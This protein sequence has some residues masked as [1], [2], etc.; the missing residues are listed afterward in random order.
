[1][2]FF[3][4]NIFIIK[5][6]TIGFLY[7]N[8]IQFINYEDY[9]LPIRYTI[10]DRHALSIKVYK[11]E[12]IK[13]L[14][15][16]LTKVTNNDFEKARSIYR[17]ITK[18]IAYDVDS[19]FNNNID[20]Q[21][22]QAENV[23]KTKLSV[24]SG[25]ANLFNEMASSVGLKSEVV[26]GFAKGYGFEPGDKIRESNHAWNA[27]EI[28]KN[29][30]LVDCTWGSGNIGF[31][32]KFNR[33]YVDFYFLT[34]PEHLI[35]SHFPDNKRWQLVKDQVSKIDFFK[36]P[37]VKPKFF[38]NR[39]DFFSPPM[40]EYEIADEL[41]IDYRIDPKI[42]IMS[43]LT[44]KDEIELE[45][46]TY[47]SRAGSVA[48]ISVR[49]PDSGDYR[50]SIFSEDHIKK[51]KYN[52]CVEHLIKTNKSY[53]NDDG[54]VKLWYDFVDL[55]GIKFDRPHNYKYTIHKDLTLEYEINP[56]T[57]IL[58]T[59]KNKNNGENVNG[60]LFVK[61][62]NRSTQVSIRPQSSGI[63]RLNMFAK[64]SSFQGKFDG[65][66]EYIIVV[67]DSYERNNGFVK[68]WDENI[69]K[70]GI[71]FNEIHDYNYTVNENIKLEYS[72]IDDLV[73]TA[74]L[75]DSRGNKYPN[76][77]FFQKSNSGISLYISSPNNNEFNLIVFAKEKSQK[78]K[79]KSIA[80]YKINGSRIS[81]LFPLQYSA[82][83]ELNA[84][85]ISPM[86]GNLD[87]GNSYNFSL[88][89]GGI[90]K[91]SLIQNG[92]WT[93]FMKNGE[94]FFINNLKLES[95]VIQIAAKNKN[96]NQFTTILEYNAL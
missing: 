51:G 88:E 67:P 71:S 89:I 94:S 64:K 23:L 49:P 38:I 17:W 25:Y 55:Y 60:A 84:R 22:V 4:K 19:Y 27:I 47:I 53:S 50:L 32:K 15:R 86:E 90:S 35:Y 42:K 12:S 44:N 92:R 31:D 10:I 79:Y 9:P 78:T 21:G 76:N 3:K 81:D 56:D 5:I 48:S 57:Q 75:S 41:Q 26:A 36:L 93:D 52:S 2:G 73:F 85:L 82:F 33:N 63:Y 65:C 7:S 14:T 96:S 83:G 70:Y 28:D 13:N 8:D 72:Y 95:G 40:M 43:Q 16:R 20:Y 39:F 45:G 69:K 62:K 29:W 87:S 58:F 46:C 37:H 30:Y 11:N 6:F 77:V 1:V 80:E 74:K 59:L 54:F 66:A 91:L 18:N 61:R 34:P 24:C 68:L